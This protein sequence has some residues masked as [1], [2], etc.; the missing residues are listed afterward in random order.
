M[1]KRDT[2]YEKFIKL[3]PAERK[4]ATA[5]FDREFVADTFKPLSAD[6]RRKWQRAKRKRGRPT[7]G[8]GAKVIS[9]SIERSLLKQ[10]DVLAKELNVSRA[11]LIARGLKAILAANGQL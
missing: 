11:S 8:N 1:S 5:E 10:S 4:K 9:V 7:V 2:P 6:Q 3:T